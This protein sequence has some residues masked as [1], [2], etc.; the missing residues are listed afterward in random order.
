MFDTRGL[1]IASRTNLELGPRFLETWSV[2][3]L[4]GVF[5]WDFR[6]KPDS[7]PQ[8]PVSV[9]SPRNHEAK[10]NKMLGRFEL[11]TLDQIWTTE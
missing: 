2:P 1:K 8:S 5:P 6:S 7:F 11:G 4:F 3:A 9:D 10:M